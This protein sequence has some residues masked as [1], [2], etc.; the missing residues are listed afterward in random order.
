MAGSQDAS[1]R[2]SRLEP[3][4]VP[5]YNIFF[6]TFLYIRFKGP[7]DSTPL[8]RE[9]TL[10]PPSTSTPKPTGHGPTTNKMAQETM[11]FGP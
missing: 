8:Y 11:S 4:F 6:F 3:R 2:S 1:R 7:N 5:F 9:L 10:L